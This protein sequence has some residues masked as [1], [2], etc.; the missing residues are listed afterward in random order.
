MEVFKKSSKMLFE[1][2]KTRATHKRVVVVVVSTT[3]KA[4]SYFLTH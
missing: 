4:Y 2:M 3:P 1:T